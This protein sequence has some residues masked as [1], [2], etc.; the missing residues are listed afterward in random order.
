MYNLQ[1]I[2]K[3]AEEKRISIRELAEF[4]GKTA[5]SL[6]GSIK[7]N[8]MHLETLDLICEYFGMPIDEVIGQQVKGLS[9]KNI[10][11]TDANEYLIKR[12]EEVIGERDKLKEE[13]LKLKTENREQN[14][15]LNDFS[16]YHSVAQ[17]PPKLK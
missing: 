12:F 2:K 7:N 6:H 1:N 3:I 9:T 17:P 13:L 16:G 11:I 4:C 8:N 10:K 15:K 14:K 5:E